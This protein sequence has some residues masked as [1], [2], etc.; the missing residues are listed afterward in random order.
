MAVTD[1]SNR[2]VTKHPA[3]SEYRTA[4]PLTLG[5]QP[6]GPLRSSRRWSRVERS[7]YAWAL[8]D[9]RITSVLVVASSV[10]QL[11]ENLYALNDLSFNPTNSFV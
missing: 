2:G 4:T 1:T 6:V 5:R 3:K 10:S 9:E 11:E 7:E 8:R